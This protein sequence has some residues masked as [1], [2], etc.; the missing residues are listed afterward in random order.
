MSISC[1]VD[2]GNA[3]N[4]LTGILLG[5]KK[6]TGNISEKS[7]KDYDDGNQ[8][9]KRLHIVWFHF[10][11]VSGKGKSLYAEK[12]SVIVRGWEWEW[13]CLKCSG[14]KFFRVTGTLNR[15][16]DAGCTLLCV[17]CLTVHVT[18]VICMIC[19]LHPNEAIK[20]H[21]GINKICEVLYTFTN[22]K[23]GLTLKI[24]KSVVIT[25]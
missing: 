5:E 1:W 23:K 3:S 25:Q 12:R 8:P 2:K 6:D 15:R 22:H 19:E 11:E 17:Y 14:G 20:M 16:R 21:Q 10:Y 24:N 18:L 9:D 7:Q 4:L 13:R